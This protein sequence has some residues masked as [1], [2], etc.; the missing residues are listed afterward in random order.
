ML[1]VKARGS[2]SSNNFERSYRREFINALA[3]LSQNETEK[4]DLL[5]LLVT[6]G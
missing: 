3:V 6:E 4:G 5:G 2:N 1:E